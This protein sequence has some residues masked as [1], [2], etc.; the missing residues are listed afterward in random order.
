MKKLY[1]L[2]LLLFATIPTMAQQIFVEKID[3]TETIEFNKLDK[4]T[5]NGTTVSIVQTDGATSQ[6]NMGEINRIH[7]S[8][9]SEIE[10]IKA[11]DKSL[12]NYVSSDQI[13]INS[14]AGNIVRIYDIIGSQLVCIRLKSDNDIISIAHLPKGIYIINVNNRTA[15][16][17]KR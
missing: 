12:F 2:F 14:D 4:I 13:A 11:N 6:A 9:Y 7:F 5:F 17:V 8:N 16:F 15:K 1:I 3:G 10:N